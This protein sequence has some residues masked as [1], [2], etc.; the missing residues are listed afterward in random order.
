MKLTPSTW[1]AEIWNKTSVFHSNR[2][3]VLAKKLLISRGDTTFNSFS[4][5][6]F[7]DW[8]DG[9]IAQDTVER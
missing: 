7:H 6:C 2:V 5:S 3:R 9:F 8:I 4:D 1:V